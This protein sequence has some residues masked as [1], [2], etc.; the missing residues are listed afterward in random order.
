MK[1]FGP[2]RRGIPEQPH[3]IPSDAEYFHKERLRGTIIPSEG[4]KLDAW[5]G[6]D[7][8]D[9]TICVDNFDLQI[10]FSCQRRNKS[11]EIIRLLT[12]IENGD[13]HV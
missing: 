7:Q 13:P 9:R 3:V 5:N 4:K 2:S 8:T 11:I 10:L 1:N 6:I 12:S